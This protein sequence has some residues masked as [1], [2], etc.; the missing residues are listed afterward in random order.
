MNVN[1]EQQPPDSSESDDDSNDSVDDEE[2]ELPSQIKFFG[3]PPSSPR[4]SSS[5][6]TSATS[7]SSS[8][9]ARSD[10]TTAAKSNSDTSSSSSSI[11]SIPDVIPSSLTS[12]F[13]EDSANFEELPLFPLQLVMSPGSFVPL[14]I[15]ESRYR[16]L[17]S[18]LRDRAA[19]GGP[20]EGRFGIV[21]SGER[22]ALIGC[23]AEVV[24]FE[25][26]PDGRMLTNNVGRQRFRI[27]RIVEE[28]PYIIAKV[29]PVHDDMPS[30]NLMPLAVDVWKTLSDVLD[31]SNRLY[32]K[33]HELSV[34]LKKNNPGDDGQALLPRDGGEEENGK[35]T[36]SGSEKATAVPKGW[37]CP[38][39]IE[40]FSFAVC[41]ILDN[42]ITGQQLM[43]QTTSTSERLRK[44]LKTLSMARQYLAAQMVIK[45]AGLK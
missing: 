25:G 18:R 15:F 24:R 4:Q 11:P 14:H 13:D 22:L 34:A 30:E 7:S 37:P 20:S 36:G 10:N 1:D 16:L 21:L 29:A 27:V 42:S 41:D 39:R 5:S 19:A 17:F 8:S 43:L 33:K 23:I 32:D 40:E 31:I 28:K 45:D 9:S 6:S 35:Q 3:D 44:Q 12:S 38:R 2:P 26:L